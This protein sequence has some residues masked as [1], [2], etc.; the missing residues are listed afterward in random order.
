MSCWCWAWA[1]GPQLTVL[2]GSDEPEWTWTK[3]LAVIA[4]KQNARY[5][6]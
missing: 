4:S 3:D 2:S 1:S 5:A 6:S